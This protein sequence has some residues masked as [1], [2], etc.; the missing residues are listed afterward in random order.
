MLFGLRVLWWQSSDNSCKFSHTSTIYAQIER[1][2][3]IDLGFQNFIFYLH[4]E[5]RR[6]D[7]RF[8]VR[9]GEKPR[10]HP[11]PDLM[12]STNH[13]KTSLYKEYPA[14]KNYNVFHK[15]IDNFEAQIQQLIP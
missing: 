11:E 10:I 4:T 5:K 3:F 2:I 6:T 7:P 12:F 9:I 8:K 1:K 15:F 14:K 13:Q